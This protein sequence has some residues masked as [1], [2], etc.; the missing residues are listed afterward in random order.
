[1]KIQLFM[2][3]FLLPKYLE[4]LFSTVCSSLTSNYYSMN[5]VDKFT[6]FNSTF[7]FIKIKPIEVLKVIEQLSST[8][9]AVPDGIEPRYI[10]LAS[11]ILMYHWLISLICHYSLVSCQLLGST[12]VLLQFIK[13]VKL[14]I[15][16]IIDQYQ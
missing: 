8:C 1:M 7:T 9:G 13:E 16:K 11:H 4:K 2:I 5:R 12:P 14:L 6:L 3:P 15:H 10:K